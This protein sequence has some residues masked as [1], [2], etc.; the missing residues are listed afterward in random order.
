MKVYER[1]VEAI[2]YNLQLHPQINDEENIRR[3]N[4]VLYL[5]N[6][7]RNDSEFLK[8]NVSSD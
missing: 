3:I 2:R 8:P 1:I 4:F 5:C 6:E 7:L